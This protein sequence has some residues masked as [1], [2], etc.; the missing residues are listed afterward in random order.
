MIKHCS[1]KHKLTRYQSREFS[2]IIFVHNYVSQKEMQKITRTL[3]RAD[4]TARNMKSVYNLKK[5][6]F[7]IATG[8]K[9]TKNVSA[10]LRREFRGISLEISSKFECK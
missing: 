10:S 9:Y 5:S 3:A 4:L 7:P 6:T 2:G 8:Q 1:E